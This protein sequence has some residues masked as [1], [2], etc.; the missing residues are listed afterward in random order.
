MLQFITNTTSKVSIID[1]VKAVLDGGCTWIQIRMKN[2]SEA[3]VRNTIETIYPICKEYKAFCILN[4]YVNLAKEMNL[5]GVHVG[6]NDMLP[7]EARNILGAEPM[8]GVTANSFL[9]IVKYANLDIDYFGVGPFQYTSTKEKLSPIIGFEGYKHIISEMNTNNIEIPIVAVGGI[10]ISDIDELMQIGVNGVA[11]S[12]SIANSSNI[13]KTT[14]EF[15]NKL[16]K[17]RKF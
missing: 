15:I 11:V 13:E 12:G 16:N 6:K 3:D 4:D 14:K 2:S 1:Q 8:L 7:S 10:T 9:D 17:Y 5:D